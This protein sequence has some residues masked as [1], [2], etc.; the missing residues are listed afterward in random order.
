MIRSPPAMPGTY[1]SSGSIEADG[2]DCC[3]TSV[4][5]LAPGAAVNDWSIRR[6]GG[7]SSAARFAGCHSLATFA[8]AVGL[9]VD[10][11]TPSCRTRMT[12]RR[13]RFC[14]A[15]PRAGASIRRRRVRRRSMASPRVRMDPPATAVG[16]RRARGSRG[17]G[18]RWQQGYGMC[19]AL[20]GVASSRRRRSACPRPSRRWR[21]RASAAGRPPGVH[22]FWPRSS[23]TSTRSWTARPRQGHREELRWRR[24]TKDPPSRRAR[25]RS[26]RRARSTSSSRPRVTPSVSPGTR[27][28]ASWR[29]NG[30]EQPRSRGTIPVRVL[31]LAATGSDE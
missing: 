20:P 24:A 8:E 9:R 21:C 7:T 14:A 22:G 27:R 10:G 19:G 29:E 13:D 1:F 23:A 6:P 3:S 31:A 15:R 4:A 25:R 16:R 18:H 11:T 17:G 12:A 30:H 28:R 26:G 5:E 2:A